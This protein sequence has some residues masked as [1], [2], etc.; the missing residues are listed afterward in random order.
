MNATENTTQHFHF[1]IVEQGK[2]HSL[3]QNFGEAL[4]HFREGI[5][6]CQKESGSDLFFQHYSQCA[7]EALELSGAHEEVISFCEK[8]RDFL[9]ESAEDSDYLKRYYGSILEREGIQHLLIEEREEAIELFK[10]AQQVAGKMA[11]PL[12]NELLNWTQRGYTITSKQIRDS[13][14]KHNY[15]VIR[16]ESVNPKIAVQ[17]PETVMPTI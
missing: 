11:Q 7:M 17:L 2:I 4:R 12:T 1:R 8:T 6:M 10:E 3:N 13:Q 5:K 14:K 9:D 15:F 16:K